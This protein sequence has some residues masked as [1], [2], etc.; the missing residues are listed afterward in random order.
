MICQKNKEHDAV[1]AVHVL[2][3]M[4]FFEIESTY[5]FDRRERIEFVKCFEYVGFMGAEKAVISFRR[6]DSGSSFPRIITGEYA[7]V[8]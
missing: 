6:K 5:I 7:F 8:V 3:R 2:H 4:K 1:R